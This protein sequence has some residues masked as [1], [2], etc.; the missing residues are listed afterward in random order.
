MTPIQRPPFAP[1]RRFAA[2][3]AGLATLLTG[4]SRTAENRVPIGET[5]PSVRGE[6]L[7]KKAWRLPEDLA[8][9]DALLLVGYKQETQFDIDRWMIGVLQLKTPIRFIEVP[10]IPGLVPGLLGGMIDD[11]MRAGIPSELWAGVVTVYSGGEKIVA[12]TGNQKPNN[13]RVVLIDGSGKVVWFWDRGFSP[14]GVLELDALVRQRG[15]AP[16]PAQ[17]P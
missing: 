2:L 4:C 5:F 6:G 10:T 9:A 12:F 16:S 17:A 1:V 8:G 3:A 11:G 13:A 14:V 15:A 7:D